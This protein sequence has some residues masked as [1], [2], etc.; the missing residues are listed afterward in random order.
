MKNS[1][2]N[3]IKKGVGVLKNPAEGFR[4]LEKKQLE[5]VVADYLILLLLLSLVAALF[6]LVFVIGKI[7]YF[8]ITSKIDVDYLVVLNY[9]LAESLAIAFSYIISG[10]FL[11]FFI[12]IIIKVFFRRIKYTDLLKIMLYSAYPLLLF[13]WTP[14]LIVSLLIWAIFLFLVGVRFYKSNKI[15]TGS[16][17]QRD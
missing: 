15:V 14:I 7:T 10:T 5:E 1:I 11:M 16:I 12:S 3:L 6:N 17:R 4:L 13:C 2:K 8:T 9:N